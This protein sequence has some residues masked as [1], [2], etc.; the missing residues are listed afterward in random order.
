MSE[1]DEGA[2][3]GLL[4][5]QVA[6]DTSTQ[7]ARLLMLNYGAYDTSY[8]NKMSRLVQRQ[9][10]KISVTD[11]WEGSAD[12]LLAALSNQ[13]MVLIAYPSNGQAAILKAYGKVLT[14]FVRQGG[15]VVITG[16]HEYGILQHYGLLDIDYGYFCSDPKVEHGVSDNPVL[17]YVASTFMLR[18]YAYPLDVSDSAFVT[19]AEV[20]GY[21][22]VGFKPLGLGKVVYLG[23]E[24]YYDEAEPNRLLANTLQWLTAMKMQ[25]TAAV[26]A[27]A[28]TEPTGGRYVR[29]RREEILFAGTGGL[30]ADNVDMKIYPNP[31]YS[32]ATLDIELNK[33]NSLTVEMSNEMGQIVAV[34]LPR[35]Q[36]GAG[37]YRLEIPNLPVGV[38][39]VQCHIGDKTHI[40]KV[41]KTGGE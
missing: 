29:Q 9:A 16:T 21:P 40:R 17:E 20:K 14:Q 19:L 26:S 3:E 22:V 8:A 32:K 35:K 37:F 10:P 27:V 13:D 41:V 25:S 18:N 39:F 5:D 34:V 23:L 7:G 4:V 2:W 6:G 30:K 38:Y 11:F 36:L 12:D 1:G 33:P 28:N 15:A 31:Y 24:Y